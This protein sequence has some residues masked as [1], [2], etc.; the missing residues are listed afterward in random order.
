F[1]ALSPEARERLQADVEQIYDQF[2]A[3]VARGRGERL[4]AEGARATEAR[5][6]IGQ[7]AVDEGLAD[8]VGNKAAA[9]DALF[10]EVEDRRMDKE[11]AEKA[12]RLEAENAQL[13]ARLE[14]L[15]AAERSR[16]DAE[17]KAF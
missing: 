11:L 4:T 2:V 15:E 6:F 17:D 1:K 12:S 13:R 7:K 9:L 5:T 8:K 14:A 10:A 16:L 3:A